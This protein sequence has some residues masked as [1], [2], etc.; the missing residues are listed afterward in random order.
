MGWVIVGL[1]RYPMRFVLIRDEGE[2][3]AQL[4][5]GSVR[6]GWAEPG[7]PALATISAG[8]QADDDLFLAE[9]QQ[10]ALGLAVQMHD[11]PRVVLQPKLARTAAR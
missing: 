6:L 2:L 9:R 1:D 8:V 4:Q 3:A 7:R 11:D 5:L 10:D